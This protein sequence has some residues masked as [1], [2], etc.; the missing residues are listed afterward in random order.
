MIA[1]QSFRVILVK[2][3]MG[4]AERLGAI[5]NVVVAAKIARERVP[6]SIKLNLI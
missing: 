3:S 2:T 5:V 1:A 6:D 4:T